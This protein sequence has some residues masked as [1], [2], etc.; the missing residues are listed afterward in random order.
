[1]FIN[2]FAVLKSWRNELCQKEREIQEISQKKSVLSYKRGESSSPSE[3]IRFIEPKIFQKM[4]KGNGVE[5]L[6]DGWVGR[7]VFYLGFGRAKRGL[8]DSTRG[9]KKTTK[10]ARMGRERARG[11]LTPN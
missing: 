10:R 7:G 9:E 3:K 5:Q 8:A 4:R 1:V 6:S 11:R 2:P